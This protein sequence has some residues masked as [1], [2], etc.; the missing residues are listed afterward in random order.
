MRTSR[1]ILLLT[2]S[3]VFIVPCRL[4]AQ[5]VNLDSLLATETKEKT[6]D[7]NKVTSTFKSTRVSNGHS[8]ETLP[9]KILDIKIQHR[10]G[11]VSDGWSQFFG[12]DNATIRI[13]ADYGI[14][15]RLMI[16]GGRASYDKQWD[17]FAKYKLL[18]QQTGKKN[19]PLTLSLLAS[20]MIETMPTEEGLNYKPYFSDRLF[21]AFQV[22]MARKFGS[23]FS[24]QLMPTVVHYNSVKGASDPNDIISLGG[25]TSLKIAKRTSLVLEY[26]YNLPG[27]KFDG[28]KNVL[29]VG[30]DI[31]TGG[32]VFQLL[33][34]NGSGIAERP[35]IT[36]STGDFFN[37]DIRIGFNISRAFQTGS[38]KKKQTSSQ[39]E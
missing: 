21:Y 18:E 20:A 29:S 7:V 25:A 22:L 11:Y 26:Y 12:L 4:L 24:L 8:V 38:K 35:F 27:Y 17:V 14:T 39:I 28:T 37:G 5:N 3:S 23:A 33:L 9:A 19:V 10:F 6:S 30:F 31:E 1:L 13:G 15:D 2:L 36:E 16:G 32:H 34:T